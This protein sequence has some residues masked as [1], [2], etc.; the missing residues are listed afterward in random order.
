MYKR[1]YFNT[2]FKRLHE[3]RKFIQVLTGPRQSG[4]TTLIHQIIKEIKTPCHYTAADV[5]EAKSSIWIEQ[6]WEA[7][8]LNLK[9]QPSKKT[10]LLVLDEIQKI[11]NWTESIKK[12]WDEDSAQKL[13]LKVVLLTTNAYLKYMLITTN[14][15]IFP[16]ID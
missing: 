11:P 3:P 13:P 10:Y 16:Q 1:K 2:L 14:P 9:E 6:Q 15:E 12:L 4:K 5:L 7:A 8:R